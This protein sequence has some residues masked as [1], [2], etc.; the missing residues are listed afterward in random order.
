MKRKFSILACRTCFVLLLSILF[1]FPSPIVN[2]SPAYEDFNDYVETDPNNHI[3]IASATHIDFDC[4]RNEDAYLYADKGIDHFTTFEH[5]IDAK[6][7]ESATDQD[8]FI[9]YV[10]ANGIDDIRGFELSSIPYIAVRFIRVSA[11]VKR[12]YFQVGN[13]GTSFDYWED[14]ALGT[15]YYFTIS[16]DA[17]N[18]LC[19]IYS[20]SE[21]TVLIDTLTIP[22]AIKDAGALRYVYAANT[23]NDN[24]DYSL[25]GDI[26]NLYLQEFYYITFYN[27]TGGIL[28][29][30]NATITNGTQIL[31]EKVT[32]IELASLPQNASYVFKN[33]TWT[34]GNS[35]TNPC[36]YT[37][38]SN[39]TIW[40][41]FDKPPSTFPVGFIFGGIIVFMIMM[42]IALAY[43]KR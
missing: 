5:K 1:F 33:F 43:T 8:T 18:N 29:V 32:V 16:R 31:Y 9:P 14:W 13:V 38:T 26:E 11:A 40:C 17:T 3:N 28:R 22:L 6:I 25:E 23:Y 4:Y 10:L 7:A 15:W 12:I 27:N 30:D 24:H 20:D 21:R 19:K 34:D 2:A 36:N 35:T 37:I 39:M 42:V 41:Y